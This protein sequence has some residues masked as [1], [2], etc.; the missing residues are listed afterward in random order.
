[1]FTTFVRKSI[2]KFQLTNIYLADI[3]LE[4][5]LANIDQYEGISPKEISAVWKQRL[6][7]G[8][9]KKEYAP[10]YCARRVTDR[11]LLH[12]PHNSNYK[13]NGS[14]ENLQEHL[15]RELLQEVKQII[16]SPNPIS[17]KIELFENLNEKDAIYK[18]IRHF[19]IDGDSIDFEVM[20]YG[21][22]YV[23]FK[24]LGFTLH[25]FTS[26][27]ANDGGVDFIG[28]DLIYCVTT[29]L[30]K[31]KLIS[32]LEKTHSSKV[33]IHKKPL[34]GTLILEI[35]RY[36]ESGEV[37][38]VISAQELIELYLHNLRVKDEIFSY[39]NY[40]KLKGK[41]ISEYQKEM[42]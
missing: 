8:Q 28:G 23:H 26:T 6:S 21:I 35:N 34:N 38:N 29:D 5:F 27:N 19:I 30:N 31:K 42:F 33:F 39:M 41:I 10:T 4:H 7:S 24:S 40:H 2:Q 37:T 20:S 3:F 11:I 36:I 25:R 15:I 17:Q 13:I 16:G 14:E 22:L 9:Y 32:D 18:N 1:M 12:D